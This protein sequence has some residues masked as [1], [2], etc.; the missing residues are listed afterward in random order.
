MSDHQLDYERAPEDNKAAF[1]GFWRMS[2][3]ATILILGIVAFLFIAL[4]AGNLGGGVIAFFIS[5]IVAF[6]AALRL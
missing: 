2:G 1:L 5:V 6:I 3:V 4:V